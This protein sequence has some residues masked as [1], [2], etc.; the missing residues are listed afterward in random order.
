MMKARQWLSH[1]LPC[2]VTNKLWANM[3][4]D[5]PPLIA[6]VLCD[7]WSADI[8]LCPRGFSF[9]K[10]TTMYQLQSSPSIISLPGSGTCPCLSMW[11]VI[12]EN[13]SIF[14]HLK[15]TNEKYIFSCQTLTDTVHAWLHPSALIYLT[16]LGNTVFDMSVSV[17]SVSWWLAT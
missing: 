13:T 3:R 12:L 1:L 15:P 11:A 5:F 6:F 16:V 10:H 8:T 17:K 4:G 9:C 7:V 14:Y 2:Q